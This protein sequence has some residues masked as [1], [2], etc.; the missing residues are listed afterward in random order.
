MNDISEIDLESVRTILKSA[1]PYGHP[2]FVDIT[3]DELALHNKKNHDYARGGKPLGNFERVA[4]ILNL[5]PNFPINKP[6]GVSIVYMLKQL[7]AAMW[8]LSQGFEGDVEGINDRL[9]DVHVYAKIDRCML[10]DK[11]EGINESL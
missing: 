9:G 4:S 10:K 8:M 1:F 3:L 2:S 7:D 5:Y 11:K 6:I